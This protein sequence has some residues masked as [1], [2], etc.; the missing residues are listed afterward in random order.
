MVPRH[1]PSPG[2][3][4]FPDTDTSSAGSVSTWHSREYQGRG[5]GIGICTVAPQLP[6]LLLSDFSHYEPCHS[7]TSHIPMFLCSSLH[8]WDSGPTNWMQAGLDSDVHVLRSPW[9]GQPVCGHCHGGHS[10]VSSR[11]SVAV[12]VVLSFFLTFIHSF[13]LFL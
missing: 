1:P 2:V 5:L 12:V 3:D 10:G 7:P 13:F 4:H 9:A 6:H 8:A 11:A